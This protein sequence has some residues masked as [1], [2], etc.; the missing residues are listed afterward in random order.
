MPPRC[1]R[2]TQELMFCYN[3]ASAWPQFVRDQDGRNTI[4]KRV[5]ST[6]SAGFEA[7]TKQI[8]ILLV[9]ILLDLFLWLGPRISLKPIIQ[10]ALRRIEALAS[11]TDPATWAEMQDLWAEAGLTQLWEGLAQRFNLLSV[12]P[13]LNILSF[14]SLGLLDLP[15][16][17]GIGHVE[18]TLPNYNQGTFEISREWNA[19][20]LT[21]GFMIVG[22][23][24]AVAY[25]TLISQQVRE[26]RVSFRYLFH[27][28]GRYVAYIVVEAL[29]LALALIVVGGPII[30]ILL[31]IGALSPALMQGL[32][33]AAGALLFWLSVYVAFVPQGIILAEE[34]PLR[35]LWASMNIVHHDFWAILVLLILVRVIRTGLLFVWPLFTSTVAGTVFAIV[36]NAFVSA[37]MSA[38]SFFFFRDSFVAWRE[39]LAKIVASQQ[40]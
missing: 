1:L 9:P 32:I 30:F 18:G 13:N 33:V 40:Q 36:A 8:W 29:G 31:L 20:L 22:L 3:R 24:L 5:I 6:L 37:G 28:L 16:L 26:K 25:Q 10:K 12:I 39:H 7:I 23:V 4:L 14:L 34:T 21:A 11:Q 27:R 2:L 38:A 35:A 19:I 15:S 17:I